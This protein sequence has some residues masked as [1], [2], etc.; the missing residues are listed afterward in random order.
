MTI[1][2]PYPHGWTPQSESSLL[3]WLDASDQ[4]TITKDGS[5]LVSAWANKK[6]SG[7]FGDVTSASGERP[8]WNGTS[9]NGRPGITFSSHKMY[10]SFSHA[11]ANT[12]ALFAGELLTGHTANSGAIYTFA[13]DIQSSNQPDGWTFMRQ[14]GGNPGIEGL[15]NAIVYSEHAL[16]GFDVPFIFSGARSPTVITSYL[17]GGDP[18]GTPRTV[19]TKFDVCGIGCVL[20]FNGIGNA[21]TAFRVGEMLTFASGSA[22]LREKAEGYLAWRWGAPLVTGHA[23]KQ[24]AP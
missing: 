8:T 14:D 18:T 24:R 11:G 23:W 19:T 20:L 17:N 6:S 5:N 10:G 22:A 1:A 7:G 15:Y 16:S 4:S 3:W 13:E 21:T 2:V 9:L 12:I